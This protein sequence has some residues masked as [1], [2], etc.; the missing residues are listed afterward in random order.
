MRVI[1]YI[2]SVIAVLAL[3]FIAF[4]QFINVY[5]NPAVALVYMTLFIGLVVISGIGAIISE[6]RES[7]E[8][9]TDLL[10]D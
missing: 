2:I 6:I 10:L 7:R 1:F 8:D 3:L 5:P 4:D 9:L